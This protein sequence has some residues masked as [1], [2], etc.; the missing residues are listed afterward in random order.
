MK[1][2]RKTPNKQKFV[3]LF[4][5]YIDSISVTENCL[6]IFFT[7][8]VN[9]IVISPHLVWRSFS[10]ILPVRWLRSI[11]KLVWNNSFLFPKT[12]TPI[13]CKTPSQSNLIPYYFASLINLTNP[14]FP[15]SIIFSCVLTNH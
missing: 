1:N 8:H 10:F 5:Y 3:L 12:F 14:K 7:N 2:S 6:L 11:I 9:W 4:I 15:Y 13:P